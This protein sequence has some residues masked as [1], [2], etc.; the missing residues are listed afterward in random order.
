M[1]LFW[2][3]VAESALGMTECLRREIKPATVD[4]IIAQAGP[5]I[6]G[7]RYFLRRMTCLAIE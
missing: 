1:D 7:T 4:E 5:K 3:E 6:S 2:N